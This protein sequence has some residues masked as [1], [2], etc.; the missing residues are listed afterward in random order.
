MLAAAP[1]LNAYPSVAFDSYVQVGYSSGRRTGDTRNGR[2]HRRLRQATTMPCHISPKTQLSNRAS[3]ASEHEV[4]EWCINEGS[5][6]FPD[7][8][9]S[10][11]GLGCFHSDWNTELLHGWQLRA[12]HEMNC[13]HESTSSSYHFG[14]LIWPGSA[15]RLRF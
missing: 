11:C 2:S 1:A 3:T 9:Y 8:L 12:M 15:G 10:K 6:G 7:V 13:I 14:F 4:I 5:A